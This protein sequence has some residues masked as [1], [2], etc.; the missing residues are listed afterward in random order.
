M[1]T[2]NDRGPRGVWMCLLVGIIVM[3]YGLSILISGRVTV[4]GGEI[5]E[6]SGRVWMSGIL[7][8]AA[9][10]FIAT[11]YFWFRNKR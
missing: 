10:A 11:S 4:R 1:V 7:T 6:N 9:G 8:M 5:V 2:Q 3:A